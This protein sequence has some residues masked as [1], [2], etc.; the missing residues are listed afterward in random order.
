MEVPHSNLS[1]VT[2]MVLVHVR[3]VMVLPTGQTATA[4]MLSVLAYD[5]MLVTQ[6]ILH[7][8]LVASRTNTSFAGGYMSAVFSSLCFPGRHS[9]V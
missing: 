6:M 8:L 4:R 9:V 1:E 5:T 2:W 7:P 3:A